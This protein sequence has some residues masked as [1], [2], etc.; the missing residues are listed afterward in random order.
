[1]EKKY[2]DNDVFRF[3]CSLKWELTDEDITLYT[4]PFPDFPLGEYK[5][6]EQVQNYYDAQD[7]LVQSRY[8]TKERIDELKRKF[9][10]RIQECENPFDISCVDRDGG[11]NVTEDMLFDLEK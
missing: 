1:M 2:V 9:I 10:Q 7:D 5:S 3:R 11:Y 8:F 6:E 4:K